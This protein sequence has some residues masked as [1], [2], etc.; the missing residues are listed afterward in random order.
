MLKIKD[1]VDLKE[2]E[3]FGYHI[4]NFDYNRNEPIDPPIYEKLI[5][6][7]NKKRNVRYLAI[8]IED[9]IIKLEERHQWYIAILKIISK[10]YIQDLIEAGLVEKVSE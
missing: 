1:N 8:I 3:K 4:V 5:K 10:K 7:I 6:Q 9:R 2:L